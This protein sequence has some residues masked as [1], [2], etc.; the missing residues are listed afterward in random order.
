MAAQRYYRAGPAMS[1][2]LPLTVALK[3]PVVLLLVPAP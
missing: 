1:V 2:I 3:L